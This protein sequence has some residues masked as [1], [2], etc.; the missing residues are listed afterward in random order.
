MVDVGFLPA[1]EIDYQLAWSWYES[2]SGRAAARFETAVEVGLRRIAAGPEHY[3]F[4]D[5]SHRSYIL[6]RFPYSII[7]RT[8][9]NLV[10][11]VALA[12]SSRDAFWQVRQ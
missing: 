12:H 9:P 5:Q 8:L 4:V 7:Y 11:V 6:R 1:A 10:L 3:G 2:Q